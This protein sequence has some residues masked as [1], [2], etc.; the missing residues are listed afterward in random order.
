VRNDFQ[1]EEVRLSFIRPGGGNQRNRQIS[2]PRTH[3]QWLVVTNTELLWLNHSPHDTSI[4]CQTRGRQLCLSLC[5]TLSCW[6]HPSSLQRYYQFTTTTSIQS[7]NS[8]PPPVV[9]SVRAAGVTIAVISNT[10]LPALT[11]L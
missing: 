7:I 3:H 10:I 2:R 11:L 6:T 8:S 1:D 4:R 9:N 5:Q